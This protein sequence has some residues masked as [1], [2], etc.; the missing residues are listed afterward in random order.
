MYFLDYN[1]RNGEL[2]FIVIYEGTANNSSQRKWVK[3]EKYL[4]V[5]GNDR[6]VLY[7]LKS[8]NPVGISTDMEGKWGD[9]NL[10]NIIK[11]AVEMIFTYNLRH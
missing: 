9:K 4:F 2:S 3:L 8:L 5:W 6:P 10:N 1:L 11:E 7:G